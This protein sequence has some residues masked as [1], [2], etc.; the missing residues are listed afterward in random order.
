MN[1]HDA[2]LTIIGGINTPAR[3]MERV[4]DELIDAD[5][6]TDGQAFSF[7]EAMNNPDLI[8]R[9]AA[10]NTVV[11][12]SAGLLAVTSEMRPA[13]V[14]AIAGPEPRS[15][16]RLIVGAVKLSLN[17]ARNSG[18]SEQGQRH[19]HLNA[20]KGLELATHTYGNLRHMKA[21]GSFSTFEILRE[22]AEAGQSVGSVLMDADEFFPIATI[23]PRYEE[24]AFSRTPV[25]YAI[26]EGGHDQF[27]T[28]PIETS[29]NSSL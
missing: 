23:Q 18:L 20:E 2:E 16:G 21:I 22:M 12:H 3:S 9:A 19:L 15:F 8:K 24:A 13:H 11:A 7:R 4:L 17:H 25:P 28:H 10:G 27:L 5:L 1:I 26:A 6:A 14:E 29:T